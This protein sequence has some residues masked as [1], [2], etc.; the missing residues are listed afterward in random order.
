MNHDGLTF[1]ELF[2]DAQRGENDL[3]RA[4][5]GFFAHELELYVLAFDD[6]D[7]VRL[8]A[9]LN[10]DLDF[11][12]RAL[13]PGLTLELSER[14]TIASWAALE[15]KGMTADPLSRRS[16]LTRWSRARASR[17]TLEPRVTES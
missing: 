13:P 8:V 6:F 1:G 2:A 3:S 16:A 15:P 10:D 17:P 12:D 9:P 14:A 4:A 11:A 7:A 5:P